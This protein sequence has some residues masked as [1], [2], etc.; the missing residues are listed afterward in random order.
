MNHKR[1]VAFTRPTRASFGNFAIGV[2]LSTILTLCPAGVRAEAVTPATD[3]GQT[4]IAVVNGQPIRES[5]L[6]PVIEKNQGKRAAKQPSARIES[7]RRKAL[8][9]VIDTELLFQ[10][11]QQLAIPDLDKKVADAIAAFKTRYAEAL[12]DKSDEEI[13]DLAL[14]EVR[15]RE[16]LIKNDLLNPKVLEAEVRAFYEKNKH[17]FASSEDVVHVRHILVQVPKD[18]TEDQKR[19][20][21][22]KIEKAS[23]AL[24]A[25]EPF[26]EV[27]KTYS[28]DAAATAG[29]DIG[30][31]TRGFMPP[32]FDVVA[33]SIE[34][35]KPSDIIRTKFGYHIL[36][37]VQ[38]YPKGYIAPFE[39]MKDFFAKYLQNELVQKRMAEHLAMLRSKA[40][41]EIREPSKTTDT[42]PKEPQR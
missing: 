41:I 8:A 20:A 12:K 6:T 4:I 2:A 7:F 34:P 33:F 29:G 19:A 31:R 25:G 9:Q 1:I 30:E 21:Q 16:Y 10:A 42:P 18:A 37:V 13:A 11:S 38:R 28:E 40:D 5:R 22:E 15:I 24:A 3:P 14:R 27:A 32:E 35:G 39:D 17:N 36:E 26:D 23:Q